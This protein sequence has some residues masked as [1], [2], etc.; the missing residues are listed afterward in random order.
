MRFD[1]TVTTSA[2]CYRTMRSAFL[3][4]PTWAVY[5]VT[6]QK[7]MRQLLAVDDEHGLRE[8]LEREVDQMTCKMYYCLVGEVAAKYV[9]RAMGGTALTPYN[10]MHHFNVPPNTI[11]YY[12]FTCFLKKHG[13]KAPDFVLVAAL[14]AWKRIKGSC[15]FHEP[16]TPQSQAR[17]RDRMRAVFITLPWASVYQRTLQ[18]LAG[19]L[20]TEWGENG[21]DCGDCGDWKEFLAKECQTFDA[22]VTTA[23]QLGMMES[24][25]TAKRV[26]DQVMA[27]KH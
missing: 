19:S 15:V 25:A 27:C 18:L 11:V 21:G 26:A 3:H 5:K 10:I 16:C 22:Y 1:V 12:Y 23:R 20:Q 7:L 4:V 14:V 2:A 17:L 13:R 8:A 6:M 9:H 24:P